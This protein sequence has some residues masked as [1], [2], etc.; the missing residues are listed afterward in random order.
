MLRKVYVVIVN[1]LLFFYIIAVVNGVRIRDGSLAAVI[2]AA[3]LFGV[4]MVSIVFILKFFKIIVNVSS[5][6]L[7]SV[8]L[9]F[10]FFFLLYNG[11]LGI[12]SIGSS[13]ID[14]GLGSGSIWRL[15]QVGTLIAVSI[16]SGVASAALDWLSKA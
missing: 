16:A 10:I 1:A 15:D 2:L 13:V 3:L 12:G 11:I 4:L 9:S 6:L 5:K 8:V 7:V 14:F